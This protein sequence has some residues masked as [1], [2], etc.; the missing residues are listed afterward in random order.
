M[1]MTSLK[2]GIVEDD[3]IIAQSISEMLMESGYS[4]TKPAKRYSEAIAMIE[5]ESPE[6]LLLDI[7]IVGKMDGIDV[8]RTVQKSFGIPYIFLTANTDVDTINRAKE[9]SPA[10]F[11]AKPVTRA[12]LHAAIEIALVNFSLGLRCT[13]TTAPLPPAMETAGIFVRQGTAFRRILFS[14]VI[15][16]ESRDNYL[17]L[18]VDSGEEVL[19][20]STLAEF[21]GRAP[22]FLQTHRSFA[23]AKSRI[24][25][26]FADEVGVGTQVVPVSK[27]YRVAMMQAL[28]IR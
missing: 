17:C 11:L 25:E 26:V 14:D 3:L 21:L 23:V 7:T 8:A 19:I 6:L 28:G 18:L 10:A 24:S 22:D 15:S 5:E 1:N 9:V 2:I 4:V 16:A 12:Q 20:R 27:T 13:A